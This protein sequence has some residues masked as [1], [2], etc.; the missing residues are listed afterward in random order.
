MNRKMTC[1]AFGATDGASVLAA[2]ANSC[3]CINE[4]SA[5]PPTP[6]PAC[7]KKCRRVSD[8]SSF[9]VAL[10]AGWDSRPYLPDSLPLG[11]R[12]VEVQQHVAD[13]RPGG[14]VDLVCCHLRV[15]RKVEG[16]GGFGRGGRVPRLRLREECAQTVEFRRGRQAAGHQAESVRQPCVDGRLGLRPHA[17]RQR[18][19]VF[20]E[21]L[22]VQRGQCLQRRVGAHA[23]HRAELTAGGVE[24]HE[25]RVRRRSSQERVEAAAIPVL[26]RAF[27]P[28][29][30]V[31]RVVPDVGWLRREH[32][33]PA[34]PG[35]QLPAGRQRHVADHLGFHA[36][37][38]TPGQQAVVRVARLQRRRHRRVLPVRRRQHQGPQHLLG[39]PPLV[40]EL[41]GQPVEQRWMR[42]GGPHR[43]EVLARFHEATAVER[44]PEAVHHH[45]G[46][47]GV[48]AAH[49]PARQAEPVGWQVLTQGGQGRGRVG[50]H[51]LPW[52]RERPALAQVNRRPL[53]RRLL[54][55]HQRRRY[56]QH[57]EGLLDSRHF[58]TLGLELRGQGA[59]LRRQIL[60]LGLGPRGQRHL[61]RRARAG[62]DG[63]HLQRCLRVG[64]GE[65]EPAQPLAEGAVLVPDLDGEHRA[66]G[67]AHGR[68]GHE[69]ELERYAPAFPH[70]IGDPGLP[71]PRVRGWPFLRQ[72]HEV[73]AHHVPVALGL[74]DVHARAPGRIVRWRREH[75]EARD[76]E[77]AV[78]IAS[79]ALLW[80]RRVEQ[81]LETQA[82]DGGGGRPCFDGVRG[83]LRVRP[84]GQHTG[85]GGDAEP[86]AVGGRRVAGDERRPRL[87]GLAHVVLPA[88]LC[89][90]ALWRVLGERVLGGLQLCA[91]FGARGLLL[92]RREVERALDVAVRIAERPGVVRGVGE[93]RHQPEVVLLAERVVLV[94]VALRARDRAAEPG[95]G[96]R[97]DPIHQHFVQRLGRVDAP[98]LVGHRI[99]MESGGDPLRACRAGQH[100]ARNLFHRE[101]LERH[102]GVE[103]LD[104]PVP[105]RPHRPQAV[106][107]VAVAVGVAREVEPEARP[108]FAEV[109]RGQQPVHHAFIGVGPRVGEERVEF[110]DGR[111]QARQV[112]R[113]ATQQRLA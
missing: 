103:R 56:L 16:L 71:A 15:L 2:C 19:R 20:E 18:P 39:A 6:K 33:R 45:A 9:I 60:G 73:P 75:L 26:A 8:C 43:P 21:A 65:P 66:A 63:H 102:V 46:R 109:W 67:E 14:Q 95:G 69:H 22:V 58:R 85:V 81:R 98:F 80:Q 64:D 88:S 83:E 17:C 31:V 111:R 4:A 91:Q 78:R 104:H 59:E 87:C 92:G 32:A 48:V 82:C 52:C 1:L 51:L 47:E 34:D 5:A 96:R 24:G 86:H 113:H 84:A 55:H 108:A 36:E 13:H 7:L 49:E 89:A 112:E 70:G 41:H 11:H 107:F 97:A 61:D 77:V 29:R 76:A 42:W 99:A 12:L 79:R 100:V 23:T 68:P 72:V 93:E 25:H 37:A 106:R 57:V 30:V 35:A 38:R 3:S 53:E 44:L 10:T 74:G 101:A 28:L 105:I 62:V 54:L 110:G 40:H 50:E 27:D 90:R 94:V